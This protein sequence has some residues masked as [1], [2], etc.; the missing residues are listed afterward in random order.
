MDYGQLLKRSWEI[1][2]NNKWIIILGFLIVLGTGGSGGGGGGGGTP[3][4]DND[5][6][7]PEQPEFAPP[8][9]ED[10]DRLWE[11]L[12]R[13]APW[14][15]GAIALV[16]A[17]VIVG[18]VIGL[19]LWAVA[20]IAT[21]G[22]IHAVDTIEGGG[23]SSLTQ[24]WSAGWAKG[25]RLL[26]IGVIPALPGWILLVILVIV[27]IAFFP[28]LIDM[29]E[30]IDR[31][32][33]AIFGTTFIPFIATII[34]VSCF[35]SLVS[36]VLGV[37]A[38]FAYRAAMLEEKTVFEAYGRG[39]EVLKTNF[40]QALILWLIQVGI[41]I[42]LGLVLFLPS[43]LIAFCCILWPLLWV[44]SGTITAFFQTAWTLAYREWTG[45]PAAPLSG[46]AADVAPAV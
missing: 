28:S 39:W 3:F 9:A 34:I 23:T 19:A 6:E 2:W 46:P 10:L 17:L 12:Q 30:T 44:V 43:I 26:G 7:S 25:W 41:G 42:G 18:I 31:N 40:G 15:G 8:D 16:V 4:S 37:L 45:R 24:A 38:T 33:E 5:Y 1:I 27:F 29:V 32:P 35:F 20:Q 22:L 11:E 21:G 13:E 36:A 14:I